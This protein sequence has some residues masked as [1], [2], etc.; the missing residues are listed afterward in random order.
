MLTYH[1]SRVL[2]IIRTKDQWSDDAIFLVSKNARV[3]FGIGKITHKTI[4]M[5]YIRSTILTLRG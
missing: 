5:V 1:H 3:N 2:H 4:I